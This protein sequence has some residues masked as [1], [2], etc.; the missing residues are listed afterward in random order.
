[1]YS[2]DVMTQINCQVCHTIRLRPYARFLI[3]WF[4]KVMINLQ[5]VRS[6]TYQTVL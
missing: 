5:F 6:Q 1:M 4:L 2:I 3:A